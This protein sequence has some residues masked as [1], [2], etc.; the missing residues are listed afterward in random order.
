MP[1]RSRP[2]IVSPP[3]LAFAWVV[4]CLALI[5]VPDLGRG[6]VKD[7]FRW[8]VTSRLQG[9]ADLQRVF[10]ET[11]MGFYRPLVAISF[12]VSHSWFGVNPFPYGLTNL[13]LVV[14]IVLFIVGVLS[15]RRTVV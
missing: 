12:G 1:E 14:A 4:V 15:G 6:F 11:P 5:Y 7:D 8:I 9:L 3:A 13:L 2:S 10:V